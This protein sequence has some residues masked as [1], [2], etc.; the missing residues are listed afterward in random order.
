MRHRRQ[1]RRIRLQ[2]VTPRRHRRRHRRHIPRILKRHDP[3]ER[4]HMPRLQQRPR[5]LQRPREAVKLRPHPTMKRRHLRHQV[6]PAL[7]IVQHHR[8]P[9]L[10]RHL[11]MQTQHPLLPRPPRLRRE[12]LR[13]RM[14]IIQPRLPQ[15][16]HLRMPRQLPQLLHPRLPRHRIHI[17]RMNPHRRK[18]IRLP[19]RNRQH[20]PRIHQIHRRHHHRRHPRRPR[21]N[22]HPLQI[23][24]KTPIPQMRVTIHQPHHFPASSATFVFPF[25]FSTTRGG[26]LQAASHSSP[27]F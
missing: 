13:R 5:L 16:H 12:P 10:H 11:Q 23:I 6:L 20:L 27:F 17:T 2:Q 25:F 8:Q 3:R 22:Q 21:P 26:I 19:L 14:K 7:P 4:N 1:I 15:R 24:R 18:H 9:R